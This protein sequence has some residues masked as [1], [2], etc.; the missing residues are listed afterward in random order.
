MASNNSL[1][2]NIYDTIGSE[3]VTFSIPW[4]NVIIVISI[5]FFFS[6]VTTFLPSKQ[7]SKIS[8]AEALRY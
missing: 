2:W 4:I 3:G 1:A 7:A 5:A 8:P 6:L